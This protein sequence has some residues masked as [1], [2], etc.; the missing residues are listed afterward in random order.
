MKKLIAAAFA[1][2]ICISFSTSAFAA[3]D[4]LPTNVL[5][6]RDGV[7]RICAE[8]ADGISTGTGFGVGKGSETKYIITNNHVIE[9]ADEITIY[10]GYYGNTMATVI[11]ADAVLDLAILKLSKPQSQIKPLPI[12][13]AEIGNNVYA[14]GFPGL[15]DL[16]SENSYTQAY[17]DYMTITSG[18]VS[19]FK[20]T[21][22]R[23]KCIQTDATISQGNSGG[24]LINTNG[25]VVGVNTF[26]TAFDI[27]SA[28]FAVSSQELTK[29]LNVNNIP[30]S[31]K[32]NAAKVELP[33]YVY[34]IIGVFS[35]IVLTLLC[36][37]IIILIK[38]KR[39]K[40]S[41]DVIAFAESTGLPANAPLTA[42]AEQAMSASAA[43]SLDTVQ[44]LLAT[45]QAY[46]KA[47]K[48]VRKA[49]AK[50]ICIALAAF[51][52]FAFLAFSTVQYSIIKTALSDQ[53]YIYAKTL[54]N[55]APYLSLLNQKEYMYCSA[56]YAF[57][58]NDIQNAQ[59]HLQKLDDYKNSASLLNKTNKYISLTSINGN[60]K[61]SFTKKYEGLL[62][63]G[64]FYD[65][66]Q[67]ASA[68]LREYY[69]WTI[70]RFELH[71]ITDET[72]LSMFQYFGNYKN[73]PLYAEFLTE[74]VN[75]DSFEEKTEAIMLF[76]SD[77]EKY[78]LIYE[79]INEK[80][81]VYQSLYGSN[82]VSSDGQYY[83]YWPDGD[84]YYSIYLPG[85]Y[86]TG[87]ASLHN[88]GIYSDDKK[89][90][91]LT[92]NDYFSI[93]MQNPGNKKVKLTRVRN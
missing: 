62:A 19:S 84:D 90:C 74:M 6:A 42:P 9:G 68:V 40:A 29:F 91:D 89:I 72:L 25:Q 87:Y 1:L 37:I 4:K 64:N 16:E 7:V 77:D 47:L 93:E 55:A 58:T 18:I 50:K 20:S 73:A 12:A 31:T 22:D 24:P 85:G 83:F 17:K 28:Y 60:G 61:G 54:Y 33:L 32:A 80:D 39:K 26:Y 88:D 14:L 82:F 52:A 3:A 43:N 67:A 86:V 79:Y 36:I 75:A 78:S 30:Y 65:S 56:M 11:K 51:A 92:I 8:S 70:K 5:D 45:P 41:A 38:N 71:K 15:A 76:A 35:F 34:I 57:E 2:I 10:F 63:L 49:R 81:F 48:K 59:K 53:D 69:N 46:T 27:N 66:P 44:D 21:S 13:D 23:V